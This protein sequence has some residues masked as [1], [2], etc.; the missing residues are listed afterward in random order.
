MFTGLIKDIGTIKSIRQIEEGKEFQ[1]I[2]HSLLPEIAVHD[3][4]A[5][6]GVCLTATAIDQDSFTAQ[7]VHITLEKTS[8][9]QLKLNDPVNLEL[10]MRLSDRLGGHLVQGH[11]ESTATITEIKTRGDNWEF[12]LQIDEAIAPRLIQEGSIAIDG[13]SLTIAKREIPYIW[14]TIIPYTLEHTL[15]QHYKPGQKV[16][17][18]T[19]MILKYIHQ[20]S[21]HYPKQAKPL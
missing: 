15:F 3:S 13:V 5:V 14:V 9:G 2:S 19:D 21:T 18:E 6:N 4:I 11:I 7:A 12:Q 16:N 17:I 20:L 10:A 8:L 1:I